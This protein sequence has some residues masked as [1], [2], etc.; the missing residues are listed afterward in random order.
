MELN[1]I[2]KIGMTLRNVRVGRALAFK[3]LRIIAERRFRLGQQGYTCLSQNLSR[4][5]N[6]K[7]LI[8]FERFFSLVYQIVV[9]SQ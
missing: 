9:L 8:N 4:V 3:H 6:L 5:K 2:D 7:Y 1:V